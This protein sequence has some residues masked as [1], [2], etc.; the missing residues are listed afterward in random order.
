MGQKSEVGSQPGLRQRWIEYPVTP[1]EFSASV[2]GVGIG[3]GIGFQKLD[4]DPDSD[5][6]ADGFPAQLFTP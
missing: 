1:G 2:V 4:P 3:I 5:P 6:D